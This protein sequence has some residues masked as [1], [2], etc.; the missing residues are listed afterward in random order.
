[1]LMTKDQRQAMKLR[2][3]YAMETPSP[4]EGE[5]RGEGSNLA[6]DDTKAI[7]E[8]AAGW[9]RPFVN[10]ESVGLKN[11]PKVK[12]NIYGTFAG[13][14]SGITE[15]GSGWDGM[16]SVYAGYNGSHQHY[17]GIGIYQNGG[18][19]G[20]TGMLYKDNFFTGLT[21]NVGANAANASTMYGNEDFA[22][23]MTGAALKTGYN[24]ELADGKFII[25]PNYQM[26]YSMV[27]TFDYTNSAGVRVK[28]DPLHAI[29]FEPGVKFIGNLPNGW[30]PYAGVSVVWNVLDKTD[31]KANDVSLPNM[32]V[33]PFVKY[34]AGVRKTWGERLT[35]FIQ[36]F[37]TNGGRNGIGFQAG[38][39]WFLGKENS[40]KAKKSQ[41]KMPE[42][43]QTK[44][45]LKNIKQPE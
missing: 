31:V 23:L 28:S 14:D 17:D 25:Q 32:S 37:I 27:N 12:N 7:S 40:S 20:L 5:G 9:F 29:T 19:L 30:Q 15:L 21:A 24:W 42:K 10:F 44:I 43:E 4:L 13:F 41:N 8:N 35:G 11:G 34:G 6:Y 22:M 3:K 16:W 38:F 26:S 33:K 36:T 39:K 18:T 2:N 1:M 45:T